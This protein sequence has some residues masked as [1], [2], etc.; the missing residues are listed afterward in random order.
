MKHLS[1]VIVACL[2]A[3]P[4]VACG[5]ASNALS[6]AQQVHLPSNTS[7]C[8]CLYVANEGANTVTIYPVSAIGNVKPIQTIG[9]TKT[10]LNAPL[11]VALD[12]SGNIY[13]TNSQSNS[14]TVY[15][16]GASGNVAPIQK[17]K[18]PDTGLRTPYGVAINAVDGNIYVANEAAN[19]V[20][21]Y[22][23]GSTG[24]A[25]PV[26]TLAGRYTLLLSPTGLAFDASG[27]L[28]V[29]SSYIA[30]VLEFAPGSSG[31]TPYIGAVGGR[32]SK[33]TIPYAVA[34]DASSNVY[35]AN[36][37]QVDHGT[38][39]V[40]PAG[41]SGR[42]PMQR[43]IVGASYYPDGIA[44]DGSRN[45]YAAVASKDRILV[46]PSGSNGKVPAK[47][48]KGARTGLVMPAGITIH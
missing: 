9:G 48:L 43:I 4:L 46:Y 35:V 18:G 29:A 15:A 45:I 14:L 13:V 40:F 24:D 7:P 5:G 3:A 32:H 20:T 44:V 25:A 41:G 39:I 31:D 38:V 19:S 27:D 22:A 10:G 23:P 16:S 47:A 17:I 28:W 34:L 37:N 26:A 6:P 12:A 42:D 8:P 21:I 1:S 36:S 30:L 2:M 33:L 11:D